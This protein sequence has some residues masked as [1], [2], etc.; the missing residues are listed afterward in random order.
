MPNPSISGTPGGITYSADQL[1]E[2]SLKLDSI[3]EWLRECCEARHA[4]DM[5]DVIKEASQVI[6]DLFLDMDH[7]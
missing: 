2:M 5:A 6:Y 1:E 7:S 4:D 3:E